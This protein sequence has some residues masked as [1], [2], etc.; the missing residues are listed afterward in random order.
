MSTEQAT[1][2]IEAA[3]KVANAALGFA[4]TPEQ[5]EAAK[6]RLADLEI[7]EQYYTNP[8]FRKA[9][10]DHTFAATYSPRP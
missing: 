10:E 3:R 8:A 1:I 9:L 2:Q 6:N 5:V 7:A 4:T